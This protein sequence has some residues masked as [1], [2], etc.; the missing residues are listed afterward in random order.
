M[1]ALARVP[2]Y[3]SPALSSRLPPPKL[4]L[5]RSVVAH[6]P[7]PF[8]VEAHQQATEAQQAQDKDGKADKKGKGKSSTPPPA[9]LPLIGPHQLLYST[10]PRPLI[11][12]TASPF[13]HKLWNPPK[14]DSAQTRSID[15]DESGR[16]ARF[17][18]RFGGAAEDEVAGAAAAA[19]GAKG[20]KEE[21]AGLFGIEGDLSW[22]DQVTVQSPGGGLGKRDIVGAPKA[23]KGKGKK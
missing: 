3:R 12:L 9:A 13:N 20:G 14:P 17:A 15:K 5:F 21:Q 1:P 8:A 2:K 16:L 10:A 19:K 6:P 4:P 11:P 22:L 7:A 18:S 23:A